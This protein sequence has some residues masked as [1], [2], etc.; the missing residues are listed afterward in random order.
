MFRC[1]HL[2]YMQDY[3]SQSLAGVDEVVSEK[4]TQQFLCSPAYKKEIMAIDSA[5]L[6]SKEA[7]DI[8]SF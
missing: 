7:L 6:P 3:T 2:L 4:R 8:A 5:C 1:M